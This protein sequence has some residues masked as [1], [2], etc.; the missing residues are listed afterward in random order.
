[1]SKRL[2]SVNFYFRNK[3]TQ[4]KYVDSK[5]VQFRQVADDSK[6]VQFRQVID[7]HICFISSI[8]FMLYTQTV[9]CQKVRECWF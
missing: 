3:T 8:A 2:K 1:L 6:C 9:W 4:Y 7:V 5:I